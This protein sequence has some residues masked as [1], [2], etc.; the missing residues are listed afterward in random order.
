MAGEVLYIK[1]D[2]SVELTEDT[3]F[4]RDI[5][6][7]FCVDEHITKKAGNLEVYHFSPQGDRRQVLSILK[8]I[9]L[10]YRE[11]PSIRVETI[12]ETDT[13]IHRV[14]IRGVDRKMN[15]PK[16]AFV[17]LITFFGTAFTLMAFHNDIGIDKMFAL[18]FKQVMGYETERYTNILGVLIP[19]IVI[20]LSAGRNVSVLV[21]T[22]VKN[23]RLKE[24]GYN[25][26]DEIRRRFMA[27]VGGEE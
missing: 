14:K 27:N 3:V 19:T 4:L 16:I 9:E 7:I 12:G 6:R 25:G 2:R 13:I 5:A 8:L 26:A 11:F 22:A 23:F 15:I 20:P 17:C 18:V 21:E 1:A 24:I 10:L